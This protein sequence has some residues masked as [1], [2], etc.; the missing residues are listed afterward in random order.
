MTGTTARP[1]HGTEVLDRE[2]LEA[3]KEFL[4]RSLDDLERNL[5]D[6]DIDRATYERLRSEYTACL[7]YTSRCV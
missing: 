7:L 1:E 5:A 4:L 2:A 3:E 6:D